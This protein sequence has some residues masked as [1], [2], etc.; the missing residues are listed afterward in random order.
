MKRTGA[1]LPL[2][3]RLCP[4]ASRVLE[5][6]GGP[7]GW[8]DTTVKELVGRYVLTSYRDRSFTDTAGSPY[9][10]QIDR[11][12]TYGILAGTGGGAF[13]PEGSLTRAQLCALLAQALNCRVPTGE[14]QF[15]DVSMD[16]WYGLCVNAVARLGLVEGVGEGRFAPDAPVSH[17]QFITIMARLSQRLN[18]Y[19]D[20]TLQEMPADAAEATGLL[21]YSGWARDSVWLLALSQKG[22]L[23]NTINLLWEPLEDIDP[24][25]VTTREEAAA[26]TCTLLNYFRDSSFLNRVPRRPRTAGHSVCFYR[27]G[28]Q[29]LVVGLVGTAVPQPAQAGRG[30]WI[31]S[32]RAELNS[33]RG[34]VLPPAKRLHGAGRPS[35]MGKPAATTAA[36][37][38]RPRPSRCAPAGPGR[39]GTPDFIPRGRN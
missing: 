7:D 30:P 14:S 35:A 1:P 17:E 18:M 24:A 27:S 2:C 38:R 26:L 34:K 9:A 8:A 5:G 4:T 15:T 20:L 13:Q 3:W 31:S 39:P 11:L 36:A 37:C 10:A 22:L 19:M 33:A 6:T 28:Q 23:G 25:A 12:A 16:D 29:Q 32:P 21:S